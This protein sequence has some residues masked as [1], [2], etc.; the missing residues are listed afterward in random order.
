MTSTRPVLKKSSQ[1]INSALSKSGLS[2][3]M[4]VICLFAVGLLM[5]FNT[6]AAEAL[7]S[8]LPDQTHHAFSRQIL[9]A[10]MG[11]LC[12]FIVYLIGYQKILILSP[13]LLLGC[14]ILL[15]LVLIPGVGLQINGARRW[16]EIAGFSLQPSEFAKLLIPLFYIHAF[17]QAKRPLRLKHLIGFMGV[18]GAP[19]LLILVEPDNGTVAIIMMT[20]MALFF[21]TRIRWVFWALPVMVMALC[22]VAVAMNMPHVKSRIKVY[23]NPELDLRGKGHQPYQAK[24]AAG[25]GKI[26]GRGPGESLQKQGYLPEAR[27]DYIAAIFAEEF[28]FVG[29]LGLIVLLMTMTTLG[30]RIARL[31]CDY[32]GFFLAVIMTFL[33]SFQA[34]L[35]L[36]VVSGLL[37]SKGT[38]LPFF[39]QG[40]SSLLAGCIALSL[41]LNVGRFQKT[42]VEKT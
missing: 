13:Y 26:W 5:V 1:G 2:L 7:E 17:G 42:Y 8:A 9:Y 30:F 35:N 11:I 24:I 14:T 23:L 21:L 10:A 27:S 16:I 25:S 6:T 31:S 41:I 19:L 18:I 29:I 38:N 15:A 34:F 28:G 33:L 3:L 32:Q 4:C 40:G 39:S 37:P 12:G 36:G 22:G 20:L